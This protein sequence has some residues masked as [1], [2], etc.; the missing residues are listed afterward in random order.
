LSDK[1]K[2][3]SFKEDEQDIIKYMKSN[4]YDKSFSYYVKGLIR[5]DMNSAGSLIKEEVQKPRKNTNYEYAK[6][7]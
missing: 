6:T 4:G 3:V 5:K 7:E 2:P 1:V